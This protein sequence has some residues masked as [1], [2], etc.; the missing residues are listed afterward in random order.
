MEYGHRNNRAVAGGRRSGHSAPSNSKPPLNMLG[1][2]AAQPEHADYFR[3]N[4]QHEHPAR[5][6]DLPTIGSQCVT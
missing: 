3:R 6:R 4:S 5:Q 2:H 1:S